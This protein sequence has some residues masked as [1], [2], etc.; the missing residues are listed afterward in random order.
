LFIEIHF[1][2]GFDY[3]DGCNYFTPNFSLD[4]LI[5]MLTIGVYYVAIKY[6]LVIQFVM[7]IQQVINNFGMR[8][9]V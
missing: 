9:T 7:T 5:L 6:V 3:V 8:I 2:G 1:A 4:L